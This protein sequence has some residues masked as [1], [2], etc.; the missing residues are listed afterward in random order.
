MP[1]EMRIAAVISGVAGAVLGAGTAPLGQLGGSCWAGPKQAC[2][3]QTLWGEEEKLHLG[4][5]GSEERVDWFE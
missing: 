2:C 4:K 3:L 1:W 5:T